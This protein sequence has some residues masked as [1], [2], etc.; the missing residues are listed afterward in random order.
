MRQSSLAHRFLSLCAI[1]GGLLLLELP[2]SFAK[3][4]SEHSFRSLRCFSGIGYAAEWKRGSPT[5]KPG[6]F[7]ASGEFMQFDAIDREAGTA[8]LI[9]NAGSADVHVFETRSGLHFLEQT[10]GGNIT[11]TTVFRDRPA[12]LQSSQLAFV[13]SRHI[14]LGMAIGRPDPVPSQY[15]GVC[16]I[17]D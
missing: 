12:G 2:A 6:T 8:R 10:P 15:H 7:P 4:T 17:W 11:V 9:G 1:A 13:S 14:V 5:M 3:E 16:E